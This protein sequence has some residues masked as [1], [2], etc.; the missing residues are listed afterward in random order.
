MLTRG[1]APNTL[2]MSLTSCPPG[3]PPVTHHPPR[4]PPPAVLYRSYVIQTTPLE[5]DTLS[6]DGAGATVDA[7]VYG[8]DD[9]DVVQLWL[10]AA[11]VALS[12]LDQVGS[13][14]VDS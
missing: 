14:L 9:P 6:E 11:S 8:D 7:R 10:Q 12:L 3:C 1:K 4:P 2:K 13:H 5:F